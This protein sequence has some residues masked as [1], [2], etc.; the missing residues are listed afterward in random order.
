MQ[1]RIGLNPGGDFATIRFWHCDI[2]QDKIWLKVL[3]C[4][5]S[6]ARIVLFTDDVAAGY[7]QRALGGVRKIAVVID[8]Q[9]AR[10]LY[11]DRLR[12]L[13]EK[14]C[15][16]RSVHDSTTDCRIGACLTCEL[17]EKPRAQKSENHPNQRTEHGE[18][19]GD[20]GN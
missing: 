17:T 6:F 11:V 2:E 19:D 3:S 16:D 18:P 1:C 4:L 20:A 12:D 7:L 9:D 15:F 10:L 8:Y 13:W 14:V 5:M